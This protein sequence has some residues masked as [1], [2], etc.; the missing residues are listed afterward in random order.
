MKQL[1]LEFPI[2]WGENK[3]IFL[4]N[5]VWLKVV[6]NHTEAFLDSKCKRIAPKS[7]KKIIQQLEV[8]EEV[9]R[10]EVVPPGGIVEVIPHGG[11]TPVGDITLDW[12]SS[13][14]WRNGIRKISVLFEDMTHE[15]NVIKGRPDFNDWK[16]YIKHDEIGRF[17]SMKPWALV[18]Y[19]MESETIATFYW[20]SK[21]ARL[22]ELLQ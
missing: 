18:V 13:R 3:K 21:L 15:V 1:R 8:P 2:S 14:S 4:P 12:A 11:T 6:E 10:I 19:T 7:D 9:E 5:V 17:L 16:E 20:H 22:V